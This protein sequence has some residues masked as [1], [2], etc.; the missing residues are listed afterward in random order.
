MEV[1]L[2]GKVKRPLAWAFGVIAAIVIVGS[3]GAYILI[4]RSSPKIDINQ[5]TVA[6]KSATITVR[7]TASGT[8]IPFQSVNLSPKTSGRLAKLFVE[9]GDR[10]RQGQEI[11]RMENSELQAQLLQSRANLQQ[12]EA[13]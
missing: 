8:V 11:A 6:V 3:T 7:I 10:V 9:Q 4:N 5:L 1:P 12:A 2:V 13:R